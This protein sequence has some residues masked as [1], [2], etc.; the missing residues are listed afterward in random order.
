MYWDMALVHFSDDRIPL[1]E[2]PMHTLPHIPRE[3]NVDA[4]FYSRNMLHTVVSGTTVL[5]ARHYHGRH[6]N[7]KLEESCVRSFTLEASIRDI[8]IQ[9]KLF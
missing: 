9:N 2:Y 8:T 4:L 5:L 3:S 1:N 6:K 7:G